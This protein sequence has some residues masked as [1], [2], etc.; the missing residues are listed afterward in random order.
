MLQAQQEYL[1]KSQSLL[2]RPWA[3][4]LRWPS[5]PSKGISLCFDPELR[6]LV[7]YSSSHKDDEG[8]ALVPTPISPLLLRSLHIGTGERSRSR[9]VSPT[10][11]LDTRQHSFAEADDGG[12]ELDYLIFPPR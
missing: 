9:G 6:R 7:V 11:R 3:L 12:L 5:P 1:P 8:P 4:G 2:P 10:A